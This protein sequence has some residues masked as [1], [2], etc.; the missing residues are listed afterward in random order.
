M[1]SFSIHGT[2]FNPTSNEPAIYIPSVVLPLSA[3]FDGNTYHY[4]PTSTGSIAWN[5]I[6]YNWNVGSNI[7]AWQALGY[8]IHGTWITP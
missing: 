6:G 5:G 8:D 4:S 2:T 7:T 3:D 1:A